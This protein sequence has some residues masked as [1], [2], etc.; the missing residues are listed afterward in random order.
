MPTLIAVGAGRAEQAPGSGP[1]VALR[2]VRRL[3]F[4]NWCK[5]FR[6]YA[7]IDCPR[8]VTSEAEG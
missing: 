3:T 7:G 2:V 4:V 1:S 8:G 6:N 5:L